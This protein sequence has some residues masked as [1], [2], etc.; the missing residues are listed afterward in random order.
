MRIQ[1]IE[2]RLTP[3]RSR[4]SLIAMSI[5]LKLSCI[6]LKLTLTLGLRVYLASLSLS[7]T[8]SNLPRPAL[9]GE[10]L[11]LLDSSLSRLQRQR[12]RFRQQSQSLHPSLRSK[13]RMTQSQLSGMSRLLRQNLGP[14]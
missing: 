1:I 3:W 8:R 12:R 11:T 7:N 4:L 13:D 2:L 10:H 6:A 14:K 9:L 5:L